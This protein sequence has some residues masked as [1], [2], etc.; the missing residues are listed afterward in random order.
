V[1]DDKTLE[2]TLSVLTLIAYG[3]NKYYATSSH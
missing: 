2:Q 1:N 3:A